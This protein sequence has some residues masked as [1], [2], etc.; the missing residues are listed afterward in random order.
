MD[1][2]TL[3][4]SDQKAEDSPHFFLLLVFLFRLRFSL[5]PSIAPQTVTH[6]MSVLGILALRVPSVPSLHTAAS[7][8]RLGHSDAC[9]HVMT[10]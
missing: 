8:V 9:I 2:K 3:C 1:V 10:I 4:R 6:L 5:H 7:Y